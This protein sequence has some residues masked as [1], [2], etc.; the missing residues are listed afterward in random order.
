MSS[1]I[2]CKVWNI[3][4]E[5]FAKGTKEQLRDSL[6]YILNDEKTEAQLQAETIDQLMRE[7]KYVENDIK[8][9]AGA[10]V[11]GNNVINVDPVK[12]VEEMMEVK[13]FYGKHGGRAALHLLISLPEE[14]SQIGNASRLMQLCNDVLKELFPNN[15]AVFAVH[16]NTDN[17][18]VHAIINSVGLD[19]RKIHQDNKFITNVLQP[20]INKYSKKYK[21]SENVKWREEAAHKLNFVQMKMILRNEIDQAIE[22]SCSF[23]EFENILKLE[24]I[25]V[26][27]GKHISLKLSSMEK[28]IRT[29]NLGRN[30]TRDAIVERL[31]TKK[32][33]FEKISV[34]TYVAELQEK[35][36]FIP[37]VFEM[38]KYKDMTAE[39]KKEVVHQLKLGRN[40][41]RESK[42]MNWQLNNIANELNT[43][44]RVRGYI[45]FYSRDGTLQG[46]LNGIVDAKKQIAH[47]KKMVVYAKNK[48]KPILI[49]FEEMK[50]IERKAY[51]YEHKHIE[52]FRPEF[53]QY[54]E[55]TRRLKRGYNKEVFEVAR[56]LQE[57][58]ERLLYAHAQLNELSN[59]YRE[60]KKYGI[61]KGQV[62]N[63]ATDFISTLGYFEKKSE[64][65]AGSFEAD[66][67]YISSSSASVAVRIIKTLGVDVYGNVM[68]EYNLSVLDSEGKVIE[69]ISNSSAFDKDF[70]N[71]L[72]RIQAQYD[73]SD[74]R[75][76]E[77]F[78][79]AR[80]YLKTDIKAQGYEPVKAQKKKDVKN[81]SF[82]ESVN[83]ISEDK[84]TCVIIDSYDSSFI[85]L[86]SREGD[87]LKIIVMDQKH[88]VKETLYVPLVKERNSG[89]Y[90]KLAALQKKYGFSDSV[91][92]F[93]NLEDAYNYINENVEKKEPNKQQ[94]M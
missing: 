88:S 42:M 87:Q 17:L 46:A 47:D 81:Y 26:R 19:G 39:Q 92:E 27:V 25:E 40:P 73:L 45:D 64:E 32:D 82:T 84:S 93:K 34:G 94:R 66:A 23:E 43:E 38:K 65:R 58:D 35:V 54:R 1:G 61:S 3:K 79:R 18:H 8:T 9:F 28:A 49:I 24:G 63:S 16:T 52:E 83:H 53:E 37:Y 69:E 70:N 50:K 31:K 22:K 4:S 30:Y 29:H 78:Q 12:A 75:R 90:M 62:V 60:L 48:Y 2:V 44:E 57:C 74:C 36:I 14:E 59:E 33:K 11:G 89:G 20:C 15:Q 72:K 21:F 80:E 7:C 67:F 13:D 86:S 77:S 41:W 85:A 5:S 10:Y 6:G 71:E 56:F 51:L 91:I 76:F 55:L 68:E